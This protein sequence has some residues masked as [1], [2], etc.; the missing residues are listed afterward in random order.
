MVIQAPSFDIASASFINHLQIERGL[1]SN[2]IAAY[3]RDLVKFGK[4][5]NGKPLSEVIPETITQFQTSLRQGQ[6]SVSSINRV[7]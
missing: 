2:S 7:D 4:F 3:R 5:L 6:L 1:A